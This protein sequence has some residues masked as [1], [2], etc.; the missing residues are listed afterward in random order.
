MEEQHSNFCC[1][2]SGLFI[3]KEY[4]FLA[5]TPFQ[6]DCCGYGVVEVKFPFCKKN[7]NPD[8]LVMEESSVF[9]PDPN[10]KVCMQCGT[11]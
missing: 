10:T 7:S 2:N 5:T 6:C 4:Q 11:C 9:L 3:H 8:M 1:F